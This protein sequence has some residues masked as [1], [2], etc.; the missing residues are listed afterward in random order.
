MPEMFNT[1]FSPTS[2]HL[3]EEMNGDVV[4]KMYKGSVMAIQKKSPNS[5]YLVGFGRLILS[6]R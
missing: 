3:A 5:L 1:A 6:S 4:V 2:N